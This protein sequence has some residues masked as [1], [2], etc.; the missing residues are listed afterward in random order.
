MDFQKC[1]KVDECRKE[2]EAH[3]RNVESLDYLSKLSI[4]KFESYNA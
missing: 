4:G 2:E 3:A 1:V